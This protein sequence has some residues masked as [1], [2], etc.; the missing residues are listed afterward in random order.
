[1]CPPTFEMDSAVVRAGTGGGDILKGVVH[2]FWS[3]GLHFLVRRAS[4]AH[5]ARGPGQRPQAVV[6]LTFGSCTRFVASGADTT[7]T[8]HPCGGGGGPTLG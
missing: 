3:F 8:T 1:V 6:S 4:T 5:D 2:V 7:R